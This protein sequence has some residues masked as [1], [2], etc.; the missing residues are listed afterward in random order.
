MLI[1]KIPKVKNGNTDRNYNRIKEQIERIVDLFFEYNEIIPRQMRLNL[2]KNTH[3][4][5]QMFLCNLYELMASL[6]L[7]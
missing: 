7:C 4:R 5:K 6:V 2:R 1:F 3:H